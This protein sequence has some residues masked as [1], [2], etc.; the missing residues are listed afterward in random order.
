MNKCDLNLTSV[1]WILCHCVGKL[2]SDT[3]LHVS[4]R[5]SQRRTCGLAL[6]TCVILCEG[7]KVIF[8]VKVCGSFFLFPPQ[9]ESSSSPTR[10]WK[11]VRSFSVMT[12]SVRCAVTP[13]LRWCRSP[14]PVASY[15]DLTPR[16]RPWPRWLK[17]C[18]ERRRG[19]WRF[20]S[21]LKMVWCCC[22]MQTSTE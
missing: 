1:G 22:F 15:M 20:A 2:H 7:I 16:G 4:D 11:T 3:Q 10:R 21:T 17:L 9:I 13:E 6:H 18:W 14:A 5:D 19:E 12:P 8:L